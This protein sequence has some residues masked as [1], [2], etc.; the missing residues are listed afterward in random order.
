M[1]YTDYRSQGPINSEPFYLCLNEHV[2]RPISKLDCRNEDDGFISRKAEIQ[3]LQSRSVSR[4][5]LWKKSD[6]GVRHSVST[7]PEKGWVV[8]NKRQYLPHGF[9]AS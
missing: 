7:Y 8:A 6:R 5:F 9:L 2:T 4:L 3:Y 1:N